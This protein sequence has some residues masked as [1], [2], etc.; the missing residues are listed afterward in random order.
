LSADA[1]T[2]RWIWLIGSV[3]VAMSAA[4]LQWILERWPQRPSD[5]APH[6]RDVAARAWLV[7]PLR[8]LYAVG[9]PAAALLWRGT[10]T[11]R[12]LGL[13]P[14]GSAT[15]WMQDLG[16][17]AAIVALTGGAL[18]LGDLQARRLTERTPS[19]H[20]NLGVALRE[21]VYHEAHWAF[22]RE[23]FVLLWGAGPGAWAGLI[24]V[25]LEALANPARWTDMQRPHRG[26]DLVV[27][28]GVAVASA[29]LYIQTQNLWLA[30]GADA[31]L[32]WGL[33]QT[34]PSDD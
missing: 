33:G 23:P 24:P 22:Y 14:P 25:A 13:H 27:R 32:G 30:L 8:L 28:A 21:A 18:L 3:G 5:D 31:L 16:W 19:T 20:H 15:D 12:G 10:L 6:A 9:I 2:E 29:M 26:R 1:L 11:S 34:A 17:G 7:Q 4:I